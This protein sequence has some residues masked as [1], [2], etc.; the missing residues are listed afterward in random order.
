MRL[1]W[2]TVAL[3]AAVIGLVVAI[4]VGSNAYRNSRAACPASI[5]VVQD[6]DSLWGFA[7]NVLLDAQL[8]NDLDTQPDRFPTDLEITDMVEEIK[9]E[10]KLNS[11]QLHTGQRLSV[12]DRRC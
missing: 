5:E 2:K 3:C 4:V 1:S 9:A 6:G 12:P 10:S 8:E 7:R 11:D